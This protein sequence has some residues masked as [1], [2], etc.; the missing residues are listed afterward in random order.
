[1]SVK[2]LQF[3]ITGNSESPTRLAVS[4]RNFSF[5]IDEPAAFGGTDSAPN[6]VEYELAS[7]AGCMNEVIH[8]VAKE[9]GVEVRGLHLTATGELDPALLMGLPSG[10]RAG[11]AAIELV[12]EVD[13]DSSAEQI[14]EVLRIAEGRCPVSDNLSNVTPVFL[15]RM[16][17]DERSAAVVARV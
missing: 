9:Q 8:L 11:Y 15:R 14:D 13:S 5:L 4:A 16:R 3:T 10:N 7:L 17:A 1:M 12:A 2:P 6:P